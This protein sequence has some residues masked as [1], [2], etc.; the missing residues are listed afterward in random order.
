MYSQ[1]DRTPMKT[2]AAI[3]LR[4]GMADVLNDGFMRFLPD[5]PR[6]KTG[7][8][9]RQSLVPICHFEQTALPFLSVRESR[10]V[11]GCNSI[12]SMPDQYSLNES[13]VSLSRS[14]AL[15]FTHPLLF[16]LSSSSS[17]S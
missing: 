14:F 2:C 3:C 16:T 15:T 17:T 12:N 7:S 9:D 8:S 13:V 5:F 6:I 4:K 1:I 10:K 11:S